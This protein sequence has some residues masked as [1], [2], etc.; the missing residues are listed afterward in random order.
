MNTSR[1]SAVT[2]L[3]L[4]ALSVV[5]ARCEEPTG[6]DAGVFFPVEGAKD[7]ALDES[8]QRLYVTTPAKLVVIDTKEKAIVDS[9]DMLGDLQACDIAPDFSHLAVGPAKAQH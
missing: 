1:R 5:T 7:C 2:C 9:I 4:V 3:V 8:R 6:K